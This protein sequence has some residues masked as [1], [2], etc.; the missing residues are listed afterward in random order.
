MSVE[1]KAHPMDGEAMVITFNKHAIREIKNGKT[2]S[3]EL[4][5][6]HSKLKFSFMR[7]NTFIE[8]QRKI[9]KQE[10]TT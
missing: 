3:M 5:N 4:L 2:V 8:N 6:G 9:K 10:K 1:V 7:D